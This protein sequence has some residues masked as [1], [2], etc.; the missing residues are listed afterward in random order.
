VDHDRPHEQPARRTWQRCICRSCLCSKSTRNGDTAT[1]VKF[2]RQSAEESERVECQCSFL[3]QYV[4]R[5]L[6]KVGGCDNNHRL[7][8]AE[9]YDP[10]DDS[11][12]E[13]ASM[14]APR[15]H[16]GIEVLDNRIFVVGG[17]DGFTTHS[18]VQSYDAAT[19]EWTEARGM[20]MFRSAL[21]CC[22]VSR[23]PNIAEYVLPRDALPLHQYYTN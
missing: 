13:V 18:D 9:A 6:P 8:T 14:S 20:E 16:F 11:W 12:R 17:D 2:S 15:E 5:V 7:N 21:S 23:L 22:V 10:A 3:S 4:S 19:N 1:C